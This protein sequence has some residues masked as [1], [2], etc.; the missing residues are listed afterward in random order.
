MNASINNKFTIIVL[1][2]DGYSDCWN[3]FFTL[4]KNYFPG[5]EQIEIILSTQTKDYYQPNFNLK[6]VKHGPKAAFS[7][8][9]RQT[10]E[11]ASNRII[12]CLT[13]DAFLRSIVNIN[14]LNELVEL[15][16]QNEKIAHIRFPKGN[17]SSIET[18]FGII[19]ELK[20]GTKKSFMLMAGFWKKDILK[21]HLFDHETTWEFEKWG[22]IRANIMKYNF[23]CVSKNI[24]AIEGSP[25]NTSTNGGIYKGKWIESYVVP[26][27]S[28]N[29][30][31]VDF[32]VRGFYNNEDRFYSRILIHLHPLL[33][34]IA[35]LK[36]IVN[37][38]FL[39]LITGKGTIQKK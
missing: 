9:L 6:V 13:E 30:I 31:K 38:I 36:S 33:H 25:Y 7:Q 32:T 10:L 27:F 17:W 34:P 19:E 5:I 2:S 16:V 35:T 8:R 18:E 29:N 26:L 21:K 12:L 11:Q 15:M 14:Y 28:E 1:S 22:S 3:P 37:I 4:L 23:F 24:V 20:P 39:R